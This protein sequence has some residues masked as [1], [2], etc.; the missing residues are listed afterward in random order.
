MTESNSAGVIQSPERTTPPN[1]LQPIA[2]G[3]SDFMI[4]RAKGALFVD[5]TALLQK[6]VEQNYVFLSRPRRFGKSLLISMLK[7]LFT[8][9]TKNFEGLAIHDLWHEA[10]HPV[11]S[12]SFLKFADPATFERDLCSHLRLAFFQAG[13]KNAYELMPQCQEINTLLPLLFSQFTPG[14]TVV[15]LI[16]EWDNPLSANLDNRIAFDT[17]KH[18]L[19]SFYTCLRE[20]NHAI[21]FILVTGIGRYSDTSLFTG[22]YIT[23]ISMDPNFADLVGYTQE[24]IEANFGSYITHAAALLKMS[25]AELLNR[26]KLYYDGFCFDDQ[27]A[28]SLYCPLS[29]NSFFAQIYS[30]PNSAPSFYSFWVNSSNTPGILRAYL[31]RYH[32]ELPELINAKVN[33]INVAQS[34]FNTATT[35]DHISLVP[36]LIQTGYLTIKEVAQLN[37]QSQALVRSDRLF[38]CNFT[39]VEVETLW[40]SVL[41]GY[42]SHSKENMASPTLLNCAKSMANALCAHDLPTFVDKLN[43]CLR[44]IHYDAWTNAGEVIYRSLISLFLRMSIDSY[45]VREEAPNNVGRAD[46]EVQIGDS[47]YVFELKLAPTAKSHN[48]RAEQQTPKNHAV[49]ATTTA[50][51]QDFASPEESSTTMLRQSQ[52]AYDQI[53]KQG[54]GFGN[55]SASVKNWYGVVLVIAPEQRQVRY[56][57][58]FTTNHELG[59]GQVAPIGINHPVPS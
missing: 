16:D 20:F 41:V 42:L 58:F 36:I 10:C 27:A 13:I 45:L 57:S 25:K 14:Q 24:E 51:E 1:D 17:N 22:Q 33:G 49:T 54:Y 21:W 19:N 43:L 26:L 31:S 2:S 23:D 28:C 5:K 38:K 30:S 48:K 47:L 29:I 44:Q 59:R 12:L 56:W 35:F 11:I 50:A 39:N 37:Q 15:V 52:K 8:N 4:M 3:I 7:E 55:P 40:V 6:L 9:G 18:I 32:N 53:I 34:A 46:I